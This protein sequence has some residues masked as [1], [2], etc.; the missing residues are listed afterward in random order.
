[1]PSVGGGSWQGKGQDSG[2]SRTTLVAAQELSG[3]SSSLGLDVNSLASVQDGFSSCRE[4]RLVGAQKP[5]P[6]DS[7]SVALRAVTCWV[8]SSCNTVNFGNF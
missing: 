5:K 3:N 6:V 2:R 8:Y 4:Q 7:P 1:M